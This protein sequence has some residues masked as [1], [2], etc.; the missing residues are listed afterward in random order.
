MEHKVDI[1]SFD[2]NKLNLINSDFNRLNNA[3]EKKKFLAV[4]NKH[5]DIDDED[6]KIEYFEA[7]IEAFDQID[8]NGDATM[9]WDEFSNFIVETGNS[10]QKKNFIDVIRNYHI[11]KNIPCKITYDSSEIIKV[12]YAPKSKFMYFIESNSKKIKYISL[13]NNNYSSSNCYTSK[14]NYNSKSLNKH[15]Y[16]NYNNKYV[17]QIDNAHQSSIMTIEYIPSKNLLVSSGT[18]NVLKFWS[19]SKDHE[20]FNKIPTREVQMIIRYS[21]RTKT[22]I[23]GGFDYVLNAYRNIEFDENNNFKSNL[24]QVSLKRYH[25][26]TI[27]DIL[28]IDELKLIVS[29]CYSGAINLWN[30]EHLE[31][32]L[33]LIGHLKG[34]LSLACI[35]EKNLLLSAGYEH[36]III[37]DLV[38]AKKMTTIPGHS[39]SLIGVKTFPG[40]YQIISGDVSGIFKVWDYRN[41]SLVQTFSIPI[42][43]NKKANTF[44]VTSIYKKRIIIG[45]DQIYVYDYEES[46]EGN[47]ADSKSCLTILYNEVF[48]DFVSGHIDSVK[49]WNAN[50]GALK[51]VFRKLSDYELTCFKFDL[52]KRKLFIGDVEGNLKLI[53]ILNGAEMKY[54]TSHLNYI[55][56]MVYYSY[57]E[58]NEGKR[59]ISA[60]WDGLVKVHDDNTADEKGQLL[61]TIASSNQG[62]SYN[63]INS[64][65]RNI[66]NDLS[67]LNIS[68]PIS[69]N[70]KLVNNTCRNQINSCNSIDLSEKLKILASGFDGGNIMFHNMGSFASEGNLYNHKKIVLV[71][72]LNDLPCLM[73]S[74][75]SGQLYF[76]TFVPVKPRKIEKECTIEN[77]SLNENFKKEKF[78]IKCITYQEEA[79]ILLTGDETGY[80]KAWN[81]RNLINYLYIIQYDTKIL[82]DGFYIGTDNNFNKNEF[83]LNFGKLLYKLIEKDKTIQSNTI[84]N[85]EEYNLD[86][87]Y[88]K[89]NSVLFKTS[90]NSLNDKIH[91]NMNNV[92]KDFNYK[93]YYSNIEEDY[94]INRKH[95]IPMELL[96]DFKFKNQIKPVIVKE[97]KAHKDGVNSMCS[98]NNPLFYASCG[99]DCTI[100]IWNELFER[101]GS[102][103]TIQDTSWKLKFNLES[104]IAKKREE[105]KIFYEELKD[106]TYYDIMFS[107]T[108]D[109]LVDIEDKNY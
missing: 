87:L 1:M 92:F 71:N 4:M 98:Y 90:I 63:S 60:S 80:I 26:N 11:N 9:E 58:L 49:I 8:V 3:L 69:S 2:K 50:T 88:N 93:N 62:I 32:K 33:W 73:V 35:V 18:D 13:S 104:I 29:S 105:A 37:W 5:T 6:L 75:N 57:G 17:K 89:N 74:D 99:Q 15:L 82:K 54:F 65:N 56:S 61:S 109:E 107:Q 43:R 83:Y 25:N 77:Y 86:S 52:R 67:N 101:I 108:E 31:F 70:S 39:Q 106:N 48:N 103:T 64:H 91:L 59:F 66:V 41:M 94:K 7:L 10:K 96:N 16:N 68:F 46:R 19:T 36:E 30:L 14:S 78:P 44:C 47:L 28:I 95:P 53:N 23:T 20:L 102:L 38:V 84:C 22:L 27:S 40:T 79:G 12:L 51:K 34:V 81:I 42:K 21:E 45:A 72:F 76:Y 85:L 97:W 24:N 55:S 100:I